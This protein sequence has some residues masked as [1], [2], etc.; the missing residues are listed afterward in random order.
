V[1]EGR[2]PQMPKSR[3]GF[4]DKIA[5]GEGRRDRDENSPRAQVIPRSAQTSVVKR[6][7]PRSRWAQ[8]FVYTLCG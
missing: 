8:P 1:S 2:S 7:V 4:V 3:C 5:E 6:S